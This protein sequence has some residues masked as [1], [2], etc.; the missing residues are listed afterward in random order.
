MP[1]KVIYILGA[2]NSGSTILIALPGLQ[3]GGMAIPASNP[4]FHEPF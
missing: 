2:S 4:V 3:P 1:P